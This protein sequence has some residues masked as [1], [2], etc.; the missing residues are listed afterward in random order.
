MT[1]IYIFLGSRAICKCP[2]G[3]TGDPFVRCND[4]PCSVDPCGSNADCEAQGNRAVCRCREGYEVIWKD[5][6]TKVSAPELSNTETWYSFWV[7]MPKPGFGHRLVW[8]SFRETCIKD[9]F[10]NVT[11]FW[12]SSS[13]QSKEANFGVFFVNVCAFCE[14]KSMYFLLNAKIVKL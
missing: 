5:S 8:G 4:N 9:F 7:L 10:T 13:N 12:I 2:P 14:L 11:V 3:F 1:L 6:A